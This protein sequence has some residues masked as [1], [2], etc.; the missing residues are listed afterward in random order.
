MLQSRRHLQQDAPLSLTAAAPIE[1]EFQ[2][3]DS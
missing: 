1:G 3:E 2:E